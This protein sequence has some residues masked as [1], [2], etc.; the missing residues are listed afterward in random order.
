MSWRGSY[1]E[2]EHDVR[3]L[4]GDPAAEAYEWLKAYALNISDMVDSD[5]D[6]GDT[7]GISL[8]ELLETAES[9]A[10]DAW[11]DYIVR[12]GTFEGFSVDPTFWDKLSTFKGEEIPRNDRN[13]FFSCSC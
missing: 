1:P 13:N 11:G 6:Y 2:E 5:S 3:L 8:E 12:G 7:S 4:I 9:H 10:G